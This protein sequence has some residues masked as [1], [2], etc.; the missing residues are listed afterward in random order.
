MKTIQEMKEAIQQDKF[1]ETFAM[2]YGEQ[3]EMQKQRYMQAIETFH[4][5]FPNNQEIEIYSAPG[6]SEVGGNHTDHQHGRVLAAGVNMDSIAIV[7]PTGDYSVHIISEGFHIQ[8][9]TLEDLEKNEAEY[10]T[11]EALVRGVA[12]G[13]RTHGHRIGGFR[14]YI[15]SDVLGGS[16]LSS[17]AAFEVLLGTI[18]NHLYNEGSIDMIEIAQISQYAEN[19][20]F[21]K[22]CG[23][24]DQMACALGGFVFIDFKDTKV[25]VVE[26]VTYDF[27]KSGYALCIID[28]KQ[29]HADLTDEYAAIPKEMKQIAQYLGCDYLREVSFDEFLKKIPV[30]REL[31]GDRSVLRAMHFFREDERAQLETQA[32]KQ[33]NFPAFLQ[34]VKESGNSSYKFLQNVFSIKDLTHQ[35]VSLAICMAEEILQGKGAVRVHGGGFAGTIQCFV[36]NEQLAE[37]KQRMELIF[38]EHSCHILSIR[39]CGGIK[40]A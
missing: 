16:G 6:R 26:K 24:L 19:E 3:K 10:G 30:L 8:P 5:H 21:G 27:T 38:G 22:P 20:Y 36:P 13:M 14:A 23:L 1:I 40:F 39:P 32:L 35:G 7:A 29:D 18:M 11:S 37:F 28:T 12:A 15:T 9:I 25:P 34:L 17:S 4:E 31:F 33:E 2:L